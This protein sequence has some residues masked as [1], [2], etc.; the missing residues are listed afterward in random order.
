M[1]S[2]FSRRTPTCV[3]VC[4]IGVQKRK[5]VPAKTN[6]KVCYIKLWQVVDSKECTEIR[7]IF[8]TSANCQL[9]KRKFEPKLLDMGKISMMPRRLSCR[10]TE[11]NN[12]NHNVAEQ[13]QQQ[14]QELQ[15]EQ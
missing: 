14:R 9:Y 15:Q 6:L 5:K 1:L 10:S 13:R 7:N 12:H 11:S 3:L 2:G 4:F 8:L